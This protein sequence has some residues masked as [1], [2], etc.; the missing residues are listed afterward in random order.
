MEGLNRP[1]PSA[2]SVQAPLTVQDAAHDGTN[3]AD[4][5]V[6]N[7]VSSLYRTIHRNL[8]QSGT[9]AGKGTRT[10][11]CHP[12]DS[13]QLL[14]CFVFHLLL[15][16]DGVIAELQPT[17]G[18]T[19]LYSSLTLDRTTRGT[20]EEESIARRPSQMVNVALELAGA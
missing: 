11:D 5:G 16:V 15:L 18:D 19:L 13:E 6:L 2:S 12:S 17:F 8:R 10:L 20:L 9:K 7:P 1:T 14:A 3:L 4:R